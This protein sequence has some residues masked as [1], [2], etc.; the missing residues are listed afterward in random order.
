[1]KNLQQIAFI[2]ILTCFS[3]FSA[4]AQNPSQVIR[5]KVTDQDTESSLPGVNVQI[6]NDVNLYTISDPNGNFA[7]ENVQLGRVDIK[8]TF[9]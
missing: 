7:I 6:L 1:M 3:T 4:Y 9:I 2:L 5:G 8:F